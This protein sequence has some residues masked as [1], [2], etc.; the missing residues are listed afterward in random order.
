MVFHGALWNDS[1]IHRKQEKASMRKDKK[2]IYYN[3][4]LI[5]L[6]YCGAIQWRESAMGVHVSPC[7][8]APSHL[9]PHPIPLGSPSP[10]T[11]SALFHASNL[12]PA[13]PLLGIHTEDTRIE[14]KTV[15]KNMFR[16]FS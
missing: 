12:D 4:R 8:K 5:T 16:S 7:P 11:L 10:P 13:I 14:G 15:L 3:W 1:K 2:I 9:S 6:Q